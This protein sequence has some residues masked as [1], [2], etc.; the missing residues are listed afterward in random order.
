MNSFIWN[1]RDELRNPQ[2]KAES[3]RRDSSR[4][5]DHLIGI[6]GLNNDFTSI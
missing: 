3:W 6:S 5:V 2:M 1:M 4:S